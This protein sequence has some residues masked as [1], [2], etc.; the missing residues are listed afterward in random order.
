MLDESTGQH[1]WTHSREH[2]STWWGGSANDRPADRDDRRRAER[3]RIVAW[4][5][6]AS[7]AT[8]TRHSA[9][10]PQH[11]RQSRH[12]ESDHSG[13]VSD[14]DDPERDTPC[15]ERE[16]P[17]RARADPHTRDDAEGTI[18]GIWCTLCRHCTWELL[19]DSPCDPRRPGIEA[20]DP[21]TER[22]H[23]CT[24]CSLATQC[25]VDPPQS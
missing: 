1:I 20:G 21:S 15:A 4:G 5:S 18:Q 17:E 24:Q 10:S 9:L 7:S 11:D 22:F 14:Q 13:R 12:H 25:T 8:E 16:T 19:P 2:V 23:P 3:T 6:Q